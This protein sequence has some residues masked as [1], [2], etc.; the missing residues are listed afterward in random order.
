MCKWYELREFAIIYNALGGLAC[1]AGR[2]LIR[3][4]EGLSWRG[5]FIWALPWFQA[6]SSFNS[7]LIDTLP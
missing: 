1:M 3:K 7:N 5:S 6:V 2:V 4:D